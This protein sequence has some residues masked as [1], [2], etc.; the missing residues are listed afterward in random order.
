MIF[1]TSGEKHMHVITNELE[2]GIMGGAR[3]DAI[4]H[5]TY[6]LE[7]SLAFQCQ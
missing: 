4:K 7:A 5:K 6:A 1:R 2:G 3:R